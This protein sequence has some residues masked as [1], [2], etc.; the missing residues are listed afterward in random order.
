M[1]GTLASVTEPFITT[2]EIIT[3]LR[4][5]FLDLFFNQI[6]RSEDFTYKYQYCTSASIIS[7]ELSI[8]HIHL[9][10]LFHVKWISSLISQIISKNYKSNLQYLLYIQPFQIYISINFLF[11]SS[12]LFLCWIWNQNKLVWRTSFLGEKPGNLQQSKCQILV[13]DFMKT[14]KCKQLIY[15]KHNIKITWRWNG[16]M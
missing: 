1:I 9:D 3:W 8:L 7:L 13:N 2:G 15:T 11:I 4:R 10:A 14:D 5:T 16:T 12:S 6:Y